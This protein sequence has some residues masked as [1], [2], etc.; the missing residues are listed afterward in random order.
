MPKGWVIAIGFF[1]LANLTTLSSSSASEA[2]CWIDHV[3]KVDDGIGIYF[4]QTAALR[5]IAGGKSYSVSNGALRDEA[6]HNLDSL[7]AKQ[8]DKFW[9][10]QSVEDSCSY[11][12]SSDGPVGT[13]TVKSAMNMPGIGSLYTTQIIRTDGTVSTFSSLEPHP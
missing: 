12:V 3:A 8:G 5:L 11:E 2:I 7:I 4:V 9:A 6:G 13:I 1:A 10:S